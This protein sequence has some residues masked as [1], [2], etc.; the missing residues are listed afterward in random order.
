MSRNGTCVGWDTP[1][2]WLNHVIT[3]SDAN[4][5]NANLAFGA[6]FLRSEYEKF[7]TTVAN[8]I[9]HVSSTWEKA[10][11]DNLD[12][13]LI[14]R[15]DQEFRLAL[16]DGLLG[17]KS[18]TRSLKLVMTHYLHMFNICNIMLLDM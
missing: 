3:V 1:I 13:A 16:E 4:C 7:L 17:K 2:E 5:E 6:M 10:T 14:I 9:E 11:G 8:P 15:V 18:S 12:Q